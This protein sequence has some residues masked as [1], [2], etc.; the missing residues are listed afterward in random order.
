[1]SPKS[2]LRQTLLT[3]RKALDPYRWEQQSKRLCQHLRYC[4]LFR[5]AQTILVYWSVRREPDLS[6]LWT[7]PKTWGLPRCQGQ[8]LVW[9]RWA[10]GQ[11]L[12][13]GA[14]GIWAP[15]SQAPSLSV[16]LVDLI[17]VPALACDRQ[18]YRLGYGGG[19]YDRLLATPPWDHIPTLGIVFTANQVDQLPRD[20]WDRPLGGVCTEEG[21]QLYGAPR[22][23]A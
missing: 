20:P 3:Q 21:V 8:D 12:V 15:P 4:S 9:H 1:M 7:L 19:F 10:L 5:Q 16:N 13:L 6:S 22:S 17:L 14:Y 2:D 18:G 11:P 23:D